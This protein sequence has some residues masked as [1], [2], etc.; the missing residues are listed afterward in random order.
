MPFS[1]RK[2]VQPPVSRSS[3]AVELGAGWGG[4]VISV[5][6]LLG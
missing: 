5:P 4:A 2:V 3:F 1:F 6:A